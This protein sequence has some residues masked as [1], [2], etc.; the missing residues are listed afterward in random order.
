M[1]EP[2]A[3]YFRSHPLPLIICGNESE[4]LKKVAEEMEITSQQEEYLFNKK[5]NHN[6]FVQTYHVEAIENL[7]IT[8]D[9]TGRIRQLTQKILHVLNDCI[10]NDIYPLQFYIDFFK[11]LKA[12]IYFDGEENIKL[13]EHV[14]H[15]LLYAFWA[16]QDK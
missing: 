8:E 3:S 13:A 11:T 15:D 9:Y 6:I 16:I 12:G 2:S 4:F 14:A 7:E 5:V 10:D 1:S